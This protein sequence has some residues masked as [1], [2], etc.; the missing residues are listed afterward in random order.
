MRSNIA[1]IIAV[2]SA[3]MFPLFLTGAEDSSVEAGPYDLVGLTKRGPIRIDGDGDLTPANGVISGTGVFDDPYLISGWEIDGSGKGYGIYVANITSTSFAIIDNHIHSA[4]GN[5]EDGYWNAGLVIINSKSHFILDNLVEY[6]DGPGIVFQG[7]SGSPSSGNVIRYNQGPGILFDGAITVAYTGNSIQGNQVG[8]HIKDSSFVFLTEN[9]ISDSNS[10][11]VHI[12]QDV[13]NSFINRNN[14]IKNYPGGPQAFDQGEES[15]FNNNYWHDLPDIYPG[16]KISNDIY[17]T[18]YDIAGSISNQDFKPAAY[19]YDENDPALE[20]KTEGEPTTGDDVTASVEAFDFEFIDKMKVEYW[21]GASPIRY[22]KDMLPGSGPMWSRTMQIP[23]D[24]S[25]TMHY[26]ITAEDI[27]GNLTML[28]GELGE[29]TDNDPP[30]IHDLS[31]DRTTTGEHLDI[32]AMI[33]DNRAVSS[34]T[35][36]YYHGDDLS[37]SLDLQMTAE[38]YWKGMVPAPIGNDT[39][40]YKIHATDLGGM[41]ST[42]MNRSMLVLDNDPPEIPEMMDIEIPPGSTLNLS[43]KGITDN[44]GIKNITWW[45]M[46]LDVELY[47]PEVNYTFDDPGQ[48]RITIHV[49]D[50][51]E[52]SA[53]DAKIVT[54]LPYPDLDQDGIPDYLDDDDDGDGLRNE[55]EILLGTD[56]LDPTFFPADMDGDGLPDEL[57]DDLDGDGWNN[58]FENMTG[59]D[60]MDPAS[61]PSDID[62]DGS[63]DYLDDDDDDDGI[64]DEDDAFPM[65]P[66]AHM[67]TDS[68]GTP[69]YLDEDD[70]GDGI[71]D[72]WEEYHGLDPKDKSDAGLDPDSDG[73]TNKDEFDEGSDPTVDDSGIKEPEDRSVDDTDTSKVSLIEVMVAA[74]ISVLVGGAAGFFGKKG[75]D[76]YRSR[77]GDGIDNDCNDGKPAATPSSRAPAQDYNGTR[78]NRSAYSEPYQNGDDP[79]LRKRPGRVKY[80]DITLKKGHSQQGGDIGDPS[81][82]E[83]QDYN[84]SRSNRSAGL[85]DTDDPSSGGVRAQDYNSSRSNTTTAMESPEG[86]LGEYQDGDDMVLRK[87]PGRKHYGTDG[88]GGGSTGATRAQDYNSSRSNTTSAMESPEGD[89]GEYQDGDDMVLRKRPGRKKYENIELKN[90][91]TGSSSGGGTRAQDYNS[92]RSNTTSAKEGPEFDGNGIHEESMIHRDIAAREVHQPGGGATGQSRDVHQPGGS[93]TGATRRRGMTDSRGNGS[94]GSKAQD[95][96]SS[97]SN[98]SSSSIEKP[99]EGSTGQSRDVHQPGDGA[100]GA[101]RRRGDSSAV[102]QPGNGQTGQSRRRGNAPRSNKQGDPDANRYD[103]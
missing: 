56:P 68:D 103:F 77:S 22:T 85:T 98:N 76:H 28:E 48:Y 31:S 43:S 32:S 102:H 27:A 1:L 39:M 94:G 54:V 62:A 38:G 7:T 45:I 57:D 16:A 64:L 26:R 99:D 87:R 34:A 67:D 44:V 59:S 47:G 81:Q 89:L 10:Y 86:D 51:A 33:T 6:N 19:P 84:G 58:T 29:V 11:G 74:G 101:T 78:S 88:D 20:D 61:L 66:M 96:N 8:V 65:D 92:S 83:A 18:P 97:R 36:E 23:M 53:E 72:L 14:L 24:A 73:L 49:I 52:N 41:K 25:G 50:H 46:P 82:L 91:N 95:Y 71:P 5:G 21:F 80:G 37:I 93:A 69:D 9:S 60:P 3:L 79:L 35:V 2:A 55:H 30:V 63:P 42:S 70:D 13:S 100:T 75:Y 15:T 17:D 4:S 90:E 12:A 40:T